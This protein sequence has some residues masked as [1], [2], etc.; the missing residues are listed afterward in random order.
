MFLYE[1][2]NVWN[3]KSFDK[4]FVAVIENTDNAVK[5]SYHFLVYRRYVKRIGTADEFLVPFDVVSLFTNISVDLAIKVAEQGSDGIFLL[6]QG[7]T[8]PVDDII[9]LLPFCL[10]STYFLFESTYYHDQQVF[11]TA[12]KSSVSAVIANLIN[13]GRCRAIRAFTSGIAFVLKAIYR[14]CHIP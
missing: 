12:V 9:D 2:A 7:T 8:F 11:R 3:F 1:Y 13:N 4:Y 14:R 10:N 5:N 6:L